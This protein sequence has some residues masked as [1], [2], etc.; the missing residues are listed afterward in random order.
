MIYSHPCCGCIHQQLDFTNDAVWHEWTH[1]GTHDLIMRNVCLEDARVTRAARGENVYMLQKPI[2]NLSISANTRNS[3]MPPEI[4]KMDIRVVR[5]TPV[6]VC[7][8][9]GLILHDVPFCI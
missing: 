8:F 2:P 6:S 4:A 9:N 3:N 7:V 1:N 5:N